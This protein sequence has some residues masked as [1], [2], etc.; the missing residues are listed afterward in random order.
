MQLGIE[1]DATARLIEGYLVEHLFEAVD[2]ASEVAV[3]PA[4]LPLLVGPFRFLCPVADV[5]TLP[6]AQPPLRVLEACELVPSPYR[7][8]LGH[9]ATGSTVVWLDGGRVEVRGCNL[10]PVLCLP[11][12]A[13][14]PRETRGD[15]PWIGGAVREPPAFVLDSKAMA[16]G[17]AGH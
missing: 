6:S 3:E 2:A 15:T 16:V 1:S 12:T 17:A 11:E 13:V 10:E 4:Y 8:R 7:S 9:A 5:S 14:T